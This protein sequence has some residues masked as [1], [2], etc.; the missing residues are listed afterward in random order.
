LIQELPEDSDRKH[1]GNLE[2]WP[3]WLAD[4]KPGPTGRYTFTSWRLWKKDDLL[5]ES[6]M[7]GPVTLRTAAIVPLK[8]QRG[9]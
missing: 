9:H 7:L 4:G 8:H 2:S 1:G 6:G 5:R 3:T